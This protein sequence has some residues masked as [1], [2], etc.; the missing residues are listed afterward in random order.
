MLQHRGPALP[1]QGML[2]I[3]YDQEKPPWYW[4]W[5]L[6]VQLRCC[7]HLLGWR[8]CFLM[9]PSVLGHPLGGSITRVHP[10]LRPPSKKPSKSFQSEAPAGNLQQAGWTWALGL[11]RQ[12]LSPQ[13]SS[14]WAPATKKNLLVQVQSCKDQVAGQGSAAG[15]SER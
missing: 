4:G 13:L 14:R 12:P 8:G 15:M 10:Q 3:N 6:C 2:G 1:P 9:C 11:G 5:G 7:P